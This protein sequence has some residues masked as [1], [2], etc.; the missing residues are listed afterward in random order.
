MTVGRW[1]PVAV[2]AAILMTGCGRKIEKAAHEKIIEKA[3][4]QQTGAKVKVDLDKE[5]LSFKTEK[6]E[7]TASSGKSAKVP[8]TFPSDVLVYKGATV[9][10]A[11]ESPDN[12]ALTLMTKDDAAKVVET[13]KKEMTS[14]GWTQQ[15]ALDMGGQTML[16]YEKDGRA[17]S[18]MVGGEKGETQ[19]ILT[20]TKAGK[21]KKTARAD[22][23]E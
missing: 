15:Q 2:C 4:E 20:V 23:G 22:A 6:G 18:V 14:K 10:M 21:A 16:A 12:Y 1:V 7:F 17:A 9:G 5:T 19:V 11:S 8:D 13:Y 3:L